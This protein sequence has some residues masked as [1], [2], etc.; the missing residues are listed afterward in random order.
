[1]AAARWEAREAALRRVP[2]RLVHAV[3]WPISPAIA[4]P[5]LGHEAADRGPTK[6]LPMCWRTY[7]PVTWMWRSPRGVCPAGR[8]RRLPPR[9]STRGCSSSVLLGGHVDGRSHRGPGGPRTGIG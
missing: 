8:P 3:D 2:L 4:I 7:V 5:R 9:R 6:L 1:M